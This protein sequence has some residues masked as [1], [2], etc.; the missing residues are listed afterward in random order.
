[1]AFL[2]LW[3]SAQISE[4]QLTST[5]KVL[6][7]KTHCVT[8]SLPAVQLTQNQITASSGSSSRDRHKAINTVCVKARWL[9]RV[10]LQLYGVYSCVQICTDQRAV[11]HASEPP[12]QKL[13]PFHTNKSFSFQE[14]SPFQTPEV[15]RS[16][17]PSGTEELPQVSVKKMILI[18]Q[19]RLTQKGPAVPLEFSEG[20]KL[21]PQDRLWICHYSHTIKPKN[22]FLS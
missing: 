9:V 13:S 10:F 5:G 11:P 20:V 6:W 7:P 19:N 1:M 21:V 3:P 4:L 18:H 8:D 14:S 22:T 16:S 15:C 2:Q 17:A 12:E